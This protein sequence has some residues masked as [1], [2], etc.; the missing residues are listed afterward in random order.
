MIKLFIADDHPVVRDGLQAIL[1]TQ[2]DFMVV[3]EAGDGHDTVRQI[4]ELEPDVIL[5]DLEMPELDGVETLRVLG[6]L[7]IE[8]P[9]T[10]CR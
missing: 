3:G 8:T 1:Q 2:A 10:A 9:G 6:Q 5:L 7:L 4:Q